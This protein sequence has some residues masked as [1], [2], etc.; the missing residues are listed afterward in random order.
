MKINPNTNPVRVDGA[1]PPK[2]AASAKL[3]AAEVDSFA[4]STAVNSALRSSPDSR[5]EAVDRARGLINDP[6]YPG[7]E[8]LRKVSQLLASQI[9]SPN[10]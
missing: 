3:P 9:D 5:P 7:P 10:E 6:A 8:T 2:P 1:Q 4:G